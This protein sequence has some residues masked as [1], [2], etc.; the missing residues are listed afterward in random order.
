MS[1]DK[2]AKAV[3]W[4]NNNLFNKKFYNNWLCIDV[5]NMNLYFYSQHTQNLPQNGL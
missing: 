4:R 3:Q 5:K 1:F 2:G